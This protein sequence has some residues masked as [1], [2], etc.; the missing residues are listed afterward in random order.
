[1]YFNMVSIFQLITEFDEDCK[2]FAAAS[3]FSLPETFSVAQ[4]I[5]GMAGESFNA[6][7]LQAALTLR[8]HGNNF[9]YVKGEP[10]VCCLF[11]NVVHM[12]KILSNFKCSYKLEFVLHFLV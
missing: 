7:V 12:A 2:K 8:N 9:Q 4:V 1:M 6:P 10:S 3:G 5:E 11:I